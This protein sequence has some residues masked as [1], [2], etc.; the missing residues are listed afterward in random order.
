[1]RHYN[2]YYVAVKAAGRWYGE[3]VGDTMTG[4]H[5]AGELDFNGSV[6]RGAMLIVDFMLWGSSSDGLQTSD[7]HSHTIAAFGVGPSHVPS[8]AEIKLSDF[9]EDA[10]D[11][12]GDN[13]PKPQIGVNTDLALTWRNGATFSLAG[14][15][16]GL[17]AQTASITLGSHTLVFP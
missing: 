1:M 6:T 16:T 10:F 9:S 3:L 11:P 5:G 8:A 7:W 4:Y 15:T 17:D 14:K 2:D 13:P 12:R